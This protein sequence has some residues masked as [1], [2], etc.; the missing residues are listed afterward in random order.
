MAEPVSARLKRR[1]LCAAL[2]QLAAWTLIA[3]AAR[4]NAIEL[5]PRARARLRELVRALDERS[6]ETQRR[7]I[8]PIAWQARVE[9]LL[10][11]AARPLPELLAAVQLERLLGEFEADVKR[12]GRVTRRLPIPL[13]APRFDMKLF[14]LA[15]GRAIVPHGHDNM[16]SAFL[17]LRGGFHARHYDRLHDQADGV[18]IRPSIDRGLAPGESSSISDYRDNVHWLTSRD[19]LGAL[20]N[21]RA[22]AGASARAPSR[23]PGRVY[24][25]PAAGARDGDLIIAPRTSRGALEAKYDAV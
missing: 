14:V 18:V 23:A 9:A 15:P 7:A 5:D 21:V 13:A 16:Q 3:R 6:A 11:A 24:L 10:R 19:G 22:D 8:D 4:A 2:A 1:Q 20:L 12:R 25:D 17:V